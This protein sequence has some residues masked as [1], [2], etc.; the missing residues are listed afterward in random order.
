VLRR[1][2]GGD[3]TPALADGLNP[4]ASAAVTTIL[5]HLPPAQPMTA[6]QTP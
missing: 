5:T 2:L 1:I 6:Q 3:R 4:V